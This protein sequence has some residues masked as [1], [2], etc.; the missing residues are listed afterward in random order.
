MSTHSDLRLSASHIWLF[1]LSNYMHLLPTAN[2][3]ALFPCHPA[4]SSQDPSATQIP[5]FRLRLPFDKQICPSSKSFTPWHPYQP[6]IVTSGSSPPKPVSNRRERAAIAQTR[7]TDLT[8]LLLLAGA[9]G[10]L[11]TP[12]PTFLPPRTMQSS[13]SPEYLLCLFS[14]V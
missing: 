12:A 6:F 9:S 5:L 4:C 8:H 2:F 7:L 13:G 11:P 14:L 10:P 1:S 3:P